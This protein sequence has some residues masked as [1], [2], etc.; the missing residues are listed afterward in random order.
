MTDVYPAFEYDDD[1][2]WSTLALQLTPQVRGWVYNT[3]LPCWKGDEEA[4]TEDIVAVAITRIYEYMKKVS[5]HKAKPVI[6]M[7]AFARRIARNCYIDQKCNA[8]KSIWD[9][10]N[11][12]Y[13]CKNFYI[14]K[15]R[16]KT[17][18]NIGIKIIFDKI[19]IQVS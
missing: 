15:M 17:R 2:S 11:T 7:S 5:V 10:N 14:K 4:I 6:S 19:M 9:R 8:K 1:D 16:A 3:A 12:S 18:I 13:I